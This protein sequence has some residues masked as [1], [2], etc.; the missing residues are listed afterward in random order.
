MDAA[1]LAKPWVTTYD[2]RLTDSY[3]LQGE[4]ARAIADRLQTPLSNDE[5]AAIGRPPTMDQTAYDL[6]LRAKGSV[7]DTVGEA[8]MRAMY[9]HSLALLEQATQRDPN[10]VLAY[11]LI[12]YLEDELSTLDLGTP[13]ERG[14][15]HAAR[16]ESALGK[17]RQLR[18]DDG[19]VHLEQ[20]HHLAVVVRDTP[21]AEVELGLARRALPNNVEVETLTAFIAENSGRPDDAIR[22]R[23]RAVTL[24]P[25]DLGNYGNLEQSYRM[26][27]RYD[28]A[29]R[30]LE[31]L[32]ALTPREEALP[33]QIEQA[34]ARLEGHAE[35][36][37]LR[38]A[39]AAARTGE[40][41]VEINLFRFLLAYFDRDSAALSRALA[42]APAGN[43]RLY[44]FVYPK[45]WFEGLNARL[46][47]DA[48]AEKE[49]FTAARAQM[50]E[51]L[52]AHPTNR[53]AASGLL[54]MIDA[55]LGRKDEAVREARE[56]A[57]KLLATKREAT[58][59]L[60]CDLAVV[61]A[62]TGQPELALP[63]WRP[64]PSGHP[65]RT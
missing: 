52:N 15:D 60:F 6:Y 20:A 14:V 25:C 57:E 10:F 36:A 54:A 37:P 38:A 27:R 29:D 23:E 30:A 45:A 5:R 33:Q 35:L 2:R 8:Q 47:G 34:M 24:N 3:L 16:A 51:W 44:D 31:R 53:M 56:A 11:C 39:L 9:G 58:P 49:A 46:R 4:I 12:A 22:A 65:A 61:Y 42:A 17:A 21:Q 64:G 26:L 50:E 41:P 32:V 48:V 1:E 19:E 18:P 62:W 40:Q 13:E 55:A 7:V 43:L 63:S 28:S 59:C